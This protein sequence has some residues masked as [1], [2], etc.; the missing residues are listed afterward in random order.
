VYS[1]CQQLRLVLWALT[2]GAGG[3]GVPQQLME[4]Q[5]SLAEARK[6]M[7]GLR[8]EIAEMKKEKEAKEATER[9]MVDSLASS[10]DKV[11]HLETRPHPPSTHH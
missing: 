2:R 4:L 8:V 7:A 3:L 6:E 10:G 5:V 9:E 1:R 11:G